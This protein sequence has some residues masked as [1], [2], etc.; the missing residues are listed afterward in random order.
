MRISDWSSDVC[1]S[2]LA[3]AGIA[4]VFCAGT[5]MRALFAAL[6]APVRAEHA[7]DADALAPALTDAVR[8]GDIV[9]IKGSFAS[10]MKRVVDALL[11]IGRTSCRERVLQ[12]VEV[13][14]VACSVKNK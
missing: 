1:S 14:V 4:A 6:P 13:S 8:P 7:T 12:Y 3:E 9:M 11:E 10:N 2:D 5:G